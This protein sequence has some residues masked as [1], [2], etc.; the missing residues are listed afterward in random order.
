MRFLDIGLIILAILLL[1]SILI[2]NN[3]NLSKAKEFSKIPT[4]IRVISVESSD[5]TWKIDLQEILIVDR[6]IVC[7]YSPYRTGTLSCVKI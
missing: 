6:G 1:A 2:P 5:G 3:S 4:Q 7:Y